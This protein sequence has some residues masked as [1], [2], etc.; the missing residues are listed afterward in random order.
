MA[1]T[2]MKEL[3]I[4]ERRNKILELLE[5]DG[6]VKVADL[7]NMFG[8]SEVTIRND[9]SELES[10]GLLERVYG[11]AVNTYKPNLN[12]F[13]QQKDIMNYSEKKEIARECSSIVSDGD[14]IIVSP[15]TTSL[16]VAQELKKNSNL[17]VVTNYLPVAEQMSY[18]KDT[19]VI[20]L[21]G[22]LEHRR[23]SI[24]GYDAIAQL[25]KYKTNK[26]ILSVDGISAAEGISTF[27]YLDAEIISQMI[28]RAERIIVVA[29]H[30][31]V[32]RVGF[33][34]IDSVDSVDLLIT[35]SK[36]NSNEVRAIRQKGVEVRQV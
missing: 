5:R 4:D 25:K 2:H 30:T 10:F 13:I 26:L 21:G 19:N 11:G 24:Y 23:Y 1:S 22:R 6:K 36:A 20:L 27:Y 14:T 34:Y 35:S 15:G 29:D 3:D 9:L 17:T 8:I 7:S 31:K 12:T 33:T 28:G 16:M 18:Y 32:G